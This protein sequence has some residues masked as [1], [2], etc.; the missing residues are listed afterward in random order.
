MTARSNAR[1]HQNASQSHAL[2]PQ[3]DGTGED[4]REYGDGFGVFSSGSKIDKGVEETG[5]RVDPP[6]AIR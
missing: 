4:R 3:V 6:K 1:P 2:K 5:T